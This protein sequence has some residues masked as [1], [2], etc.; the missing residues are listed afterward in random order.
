MKYVSAIVTFAPAIFVNA[1]IV[2]GSVKP[3]IAIVAISGTAMAYMLNSR[4]D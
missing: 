1:F 2:F 3:A 4:L